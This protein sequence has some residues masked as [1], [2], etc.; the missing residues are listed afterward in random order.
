LLNNLANN[1]K[2]S[3]ADD[4]DIESKSSSSFDKLRTNLESDSQSLENLLKRQNINLEQF[5]KT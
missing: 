1:S 5:K 3:L 4:E 2:K